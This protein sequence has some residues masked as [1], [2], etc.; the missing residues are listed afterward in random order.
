MLCDAAADGGGAGFHDVALVVQPG[1]HLA[2]IA[3]VKH[4]QF[5][6]VV[7]FQWEKA[8]PIFISGHNPEHLVEDVV[9]EGCRVAGAPLA[10]AQIQT[11][12]FTRRI[13]VR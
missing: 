3:L 7:N 2:A 4:R 8:C 12:A 5:V 1:K 11:N 13:T 10:P 9:F 6:L